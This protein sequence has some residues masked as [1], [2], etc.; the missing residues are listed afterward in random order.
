MVYFSTLD[1]TLGQPST[2]RFISYTRGLD[3]LRQGYP[4]LDVAAV[5]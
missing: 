4:D 3:C 5:T 2:E 1:L